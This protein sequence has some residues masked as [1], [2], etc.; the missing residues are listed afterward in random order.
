MASTHSS[1]P[2]ASWAKASPARPRAGVETAIGQKGIALPQAQQF[3]EIA[4]SQRG[5]NGWLLQAARC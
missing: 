3:S 2:F 1:V 5:I 4:R